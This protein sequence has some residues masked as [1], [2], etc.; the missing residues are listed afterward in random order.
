MRSGQCGPANVFGPAMQ[1]NVVSSRGE[2]REQVG[3]D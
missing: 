1:V 2:R 3:I